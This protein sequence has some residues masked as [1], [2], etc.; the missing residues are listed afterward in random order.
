MFGKRRNDA[1]SE[2]LQSESSRQSLE[3]PVMNDLSRKPLSAADEA[4][5]NRLGVISEGFEC[6]GSIRFDGPL[7]LDGRFKGTMSVKS[8][9]IGKTGDCEADLRCKSLVV[10]G[11]FTGKAV[12]EE[13]EVATGAI[14][15]AD[16]TYGRIRVAAD[17]H[18]RGRLS[19]QPID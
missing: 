2:S 11:R 9:T 18:I 14:I 15:L 19:H 1:S 5:R 13:L 3:P 16:V 17:S 4:S 6:E 8:L 12:C 10:R 7:Q